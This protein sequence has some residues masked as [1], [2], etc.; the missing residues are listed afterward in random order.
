[1]LYNGQNDGRAVSGFLPCHLSSVSG[2]PDYSKPIGLHDFVALTVR[3]RR[4]LEMF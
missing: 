4:D 1:M 3:W 2:L